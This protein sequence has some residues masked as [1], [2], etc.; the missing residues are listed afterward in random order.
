MPKKLTQEEFIVEAVAV[1]GVG[2]YDYSQTVYNGGRNKVE[3]GC[4]IHGKFEQ[5]PGNHTIQRHGC[6][7]CGKKSMASTQRLG[8]EKFI[9][10]ALAVH[11]I[12]RYEYIDVI[13]LRLR[14]S[15]HNTEFLSKHQIITSQAR[16]DK[17]RT[18]QPVEGRRQSMG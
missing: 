14:L 6:P 16:L 18:V 9:K 7:R 15:A 10:K 3:I 1:H 17:G 12:G 11:G 8:A 2:R 5:L 4:F 13:R